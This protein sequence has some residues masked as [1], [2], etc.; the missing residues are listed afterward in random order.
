MELP[1]EFSRVS[2]D[3]E[4]YEDTQ[5]FIK[6]KVTNTSRF[7]VDGIDITSYTIKEDGEKTIKNYCKKITGIKSRIM[8]KDFF[9]INVTV[10]IDT[11]YNEYIVIH[12]KKY[13]SA[14]DLAFNIKGN[15]IVTRME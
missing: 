13:I 7:P 1:L 2:P 11:P 12:G 8:P 15:L 4:C 10:K 3:S 5:K 6:Y 14:I 9:I